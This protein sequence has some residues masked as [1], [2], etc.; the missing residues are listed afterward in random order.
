MT[1]QQ[2]RSLRVFQHVT[3]ASIGF[4]WWLRRPKL[5]IIIQKQATEAG[6]RIYCESLA[7]KKYS[8]RIVAKI[9]IIITG[10][11]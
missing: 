10:I 8:K 11:C 4:V 2:Q 9:I 6:Q 1:H 5:S 3:I 7:L